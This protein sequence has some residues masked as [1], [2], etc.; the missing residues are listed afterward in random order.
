MG[1]GDGANPL[2]P[3]VYMLVPIAIFHVFPYHYTNTKQQ[4]FTFPC[5]GI[6]DIEYHCAY[7]HDVM[8]SDKHAWYVEWL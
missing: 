8:H 1:L 4:W 3:E 7:S 2:T 5:Y 6:C